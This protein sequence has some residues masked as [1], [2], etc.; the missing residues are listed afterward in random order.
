[1]MASP[2]PFI[3]VC[4]RMS[5]VCGAD[6]EQLVRYSRQMKKTQVQKVKRTAR[7]ALSVL[8]ITIVQK[9]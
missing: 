9:K 5:E 7:R 6:V 3:E 2:P 8:F 4:L 1:M